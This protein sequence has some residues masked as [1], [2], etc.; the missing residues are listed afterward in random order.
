MSM[1]RSENMARIRG[2]DTK[3]ELLLRKS[4][5][6]KG[7]RYRKHK[8]IL[9]TRPDLVFSAQRVAVFVDGCF[10]HGCPSHYVQPKTRTEFWSDKLAENNERDQRQIE[11][12][13]TAGWTV[14]RLWEHEIEDG[15]DSAVEKVLSFLQGTKAQCSSFRVIRVE[16]RI[17]DTKQW[18]IK[19]IRSNNEALKFMCPANQDRPSELRSLTNV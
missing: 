16:N 10:W 5:W 19:D 6:A 2:T 3:P 14:V 12:L 7:V 17:D 1:T 11:K 15:L 8:R 18:V 13:E 9:N 4:L